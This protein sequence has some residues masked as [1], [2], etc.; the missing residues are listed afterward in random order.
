MA[1]L[2]QAEHSIR[3][4]IWTRGDR[5]EGHQGIGVVEVMRLKEVVQIVHAAWEVNRA[6]S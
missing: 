5:F 6:T 2:N 1:E 4:P 3:Y